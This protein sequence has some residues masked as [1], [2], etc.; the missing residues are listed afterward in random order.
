MLIQKG[1]DALTRGVGTAGVLLEGRGSSVEVVGGQQ[2]EV[3]GQQERETAGAALSPIAVDEEALASVI[4]RKSEVEEDGEH[5]K[6]EKRCR[7]VNHVEVEFSI[8]E[9]VEVVGVL[10]CW[11]ADYLSMTRF[12]G[13]EENVRS[14]MGAVAFVSGEDSWEFGEH[15]ECEVVWVSRDYR[16][17][18]C[19]L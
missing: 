6:V 5:L 9:G 16:M 15:E 12:S 11:L 17:W 18:V 14:G 10:G 4:P 19:R 7:W 2:M 1:D 13:V 8:A 3:G